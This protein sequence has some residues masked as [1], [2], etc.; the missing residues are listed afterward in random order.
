MKRRGE[1]S[2][3]RAM[4]DPIAGQDEGDGYHTAASSQCNGDIRLCA[5]AGSSM[6]V[7]LHRE[8]GRSPERSPGT[9]RIRGEDGTIR[10]PRM[11]DPS[12]FVATWK[13]KNVGNCRE[14]GAPNSSPK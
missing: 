4:L 7:S 9:G 10:M 13:K 1:A 2:F 6:H 3:S 5:I 8:R 11:T 12:R 14:R